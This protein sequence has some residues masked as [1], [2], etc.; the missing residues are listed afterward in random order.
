MK[1]G[2][3]PAGAELKPGERFAAKGVNG[4]DVVLLIEGVR[5]DELDVRWMH[6]LAEEDIVYRVEVTK[7]TDR[8]PPPLPAEALSL[9]E[10]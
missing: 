10:T 4:A 5:G 8:T 1:R 6:P 7:I 3:F 2:D 9:E